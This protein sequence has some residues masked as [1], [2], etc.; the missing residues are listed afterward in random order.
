MHKKLFLI[1]FINSMLAMNSHRKYFFILSC[2]ILFL[3][4]CNHWKGKIAK[5]T[6]AFD[7]VIYQ[8]DPLATYVLDKR[9]S[10]CVVSDNLPVKNFAIVDSLMFVD[11]GRDHGM[12]E[13]L[14]MNDFLSK[15]SFG[16]K[17]RASGEFTNGINLGLYTTFRKKGNTLCATLYDMVT[18][19][20]FSVDISSFLKH[21]KAILVEEFKNTEIPQPAFWVKQLSDSVLFAKVLTNEE[22]TQ[23]RLLVRNGNVENLKSMAFADEF[24]VPQNTDFNMISTLIGVSPD[25]RKCV[26][27]MLDMNYMNVYTPMS[28]K[29]FTV[30][31]GDK[32]DLLSDAL[33]LSKAERRYMFADVRAYDF[34][35]AVLKYD[36]DERT[37]EAGDDFKPTILVLDWNGKSLGEL[38]PN[39]KFNHFDMDVRKGFLY[40]LDAESRIRQYSIPAIK[41]WNNHSSRAK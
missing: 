24:A 11:T 30:C 18:G 26:E 1:E 28:G 5:E 4:S 41:S 13:V 36:I 34:G 22:T 8:K 19:K 25:Q 10:R 27:A 6:M 37:Y 23:R 9:K 14:S 16:N 40:V 2:T 7:T 20:V 35:F 39:I 3:A 32:L 33:S 21:G 38:K 29:G 15:G 31:C 17:G 12:V